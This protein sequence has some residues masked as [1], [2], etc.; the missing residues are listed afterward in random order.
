MEYKWQIACHFSFLFLKRK[1]KSIAQMVREM[2]ANMWEAVSGQRERKK[3]IWK[4]QKSKWLLDARVICISTQLSVISSN[5]CNAF[6]HSSRLVSLVHVVFSEWI[7]CAW[8]RTCNCILCKYEHN[9]P[10]AYDVLWCNECEK[11]KKGPLFGLFHSNAYLKSFEFL[12]L[13]LFHSIWFSLRFF[14]WLFRVCVCVAWP[15][16]SH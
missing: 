15:W 7:R 2:K 14:L 9:G 13:L 10:P 6:I 16:A 3:Q 12:F 11:K 5:L 4:S 1:I 8:R